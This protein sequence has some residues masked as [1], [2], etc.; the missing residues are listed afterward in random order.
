MRRRFILAA[1]FAAA[2]TLASYKADAAPQ[3]LAAL[4][5]ESGIDLNC[6]G[7]ICAAELS[8]YCLQRERPAPSMGTA[9]VPAKP[10]HFTLVLT[11]D[12]GAEVRLPAGD[13]MTFLEHRGFM[14]VAATIELGRMK[15]LGATN[16]KL[17][18]WQNASLIP[19]PEANDPNPLTDDEIA[20]VTDSLRQHGQSYVDKTTKAATAQLLAKLNSALPLDGAVEARNFDGM[21]KSAI[22]DEL[23]LSADM[24]GLTGA[25]D[26]F[27]ECLDGTASY[28][29]SGLKR[30]MDFQ[31]DD[32][33]R[34]LNI[35]YW[36]NQP[37]S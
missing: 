33:L 11:N 30:C 5:V 36:Q 9:Y 7:G 16:A 3:I 27:N 1:A 20:Y 23:P 13:H 17:V 2:F 28:R 10:E 25:R 22:G 31:H 24:P 21:W 26:A 14:A 4:P 34:N 19:V 18:V 32:L 15:A 8:T 6:S 12:E 35:D 37:G 29:L